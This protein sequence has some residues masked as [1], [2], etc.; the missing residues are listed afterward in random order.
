LDAMP[1]QVAILD[2]TG[3]IVAVNESWRNFGR[4]N[5]GPAIDSSVGMNYFDQC[6]ATDDPARADGLQ[7]SKGLEQI[8]SGQSDLFVLQYRCDAPRAPAWYQMTITPLGSGVRRGAVVMHVDVTEHYRAEEREADLRGLIEMMVDFAPI[9]ILVHRNFVPILANR[10]MARIFGYTTPDDV[11]ALAD[12]RSLVDPSDLDALTQRINSSRSDEDI[13]AVV[14]QFTGLRVDGTKITV[15]LR[16]FPIHWGTDMAVC[17]MMTDITAKLLLDE[18][19]RTSQRLEALGQLTGGIAHDFNNL[20][21]VILGNSD[22]LIEQLDDPHQRNLAEKTANMAERGAAL[23]KRLLAFARM[24]PLD[25]QVLD[26]NARLDTIDDLLQSALGRQVEI[27]L[28]K[29]AGLW[30]ALV[31]PEELDNAILNLCLNARDAM[32][33]GGRLTIETA[34]VH[35]DKPDGSESTGG[36]AGPHVMIAV[37]DDGTGMDAGTAKRVF[38]PFFTTKSVGMGTGLGLSRV[39]GFVK[40]S[41]G[42]ILVYSELGHG[43]SFKLYFPS[44]TGGVSPVPAEDDVADTVVLP[45]PAVKQRILVVEDDDSVRRLVIEQL[46]GL[47]YEVVAVASSAAA[48]EA[49]HKDIRFDLLFTDI[50]MPGGMNGRELAEEIT[51]MR[52]ELPVVFTSGFSANAISHH[53][54]LAPGVVLLPKPYRRQELARI[55]RH[56][57]DEDADHDA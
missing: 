2:E 26:I 42:R 35:L 11:L 6:R 25:P 40:Q 5:D 27:K 37:S 12:S 10:E 44:V 46:T 24:Q 4:S 34:N 14:H 33:G 36:A 20:L 15:E 28:A 1:A 3:Q 41:K 51:R 45:K 21:T 55:I 57:L 8:L 29:G 49:V 53:G 54:H 38:E 18:Q 23:T 7:A 13:A 48:L 52:P 16:V 9:G 30:P 39:Y 17:A 50:I 43:T 19:T 32:P 56:A 47:G 22:L 31:D